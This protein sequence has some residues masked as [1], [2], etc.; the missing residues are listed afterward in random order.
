MVHGV[1]FVLAFTI[2]NT[3]DLVLLPKANF[4]CFTC[5]F[6]AKAYITSLCAARTQ[7]HSL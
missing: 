6:V 1:Y 4:S 5:C 7:D 2:F 3:I